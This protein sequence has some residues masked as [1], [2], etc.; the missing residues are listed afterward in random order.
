MLDSGGLEMSTFQSLRPRACVDAG[1][2]GI[3]HVARSVQ[4]KIEPSAKSW[5]EQATAV[6]RLENASPLKFFIKDK[7]LRRI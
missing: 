6:A 7:V 5:G 3:P 4:A 2:R 1:G